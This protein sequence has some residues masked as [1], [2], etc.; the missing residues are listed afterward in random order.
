M[1]PTRHILTA[2]IHYSVD[3]IF[4]ED[5]M[6]LPWHVPIAEWHLHGVR[7][8]EIKRGVSRHVVIFVKTPRFSYCI[9]EIGLEVSKKEVSNYEMLLLNGIHTL[10]PVGTVS[11]EEAVIES[12]APIGTQYERTVT[13][14]TVTLLVEKVLPDSEL[15]QR[16]FSFVSR[17]AIWDAIAELFVELHTN[18]IL[19]G[20]ASLANTL[21]KFEKIDVPFVGKKTFLKAYLADAETVEVFPTLSAAQRESEI[22]YFFDSMD[23]LNEDLRISGLQRD[24]LTTENDKQYFRSR[25]DLLFT[26]EEKKKLFFRQTTFNIDAVLGLVSNPAYVDMFLEHIEEHKWYLCERTG[27]QVTLAEATQNWFTAIYAPL[28]KLF[29]TEG[30]LECFPGKTAA[31]LYIEIMTHKYFLSTQAGTDVGMV[32]AMNDYADTFGAVANTQSFMKKITDTMKSL[33]GFTPARRGQ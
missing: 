26:A 23:S 13:A 14:H 3:P 20:D 12:G 31:E 7:I 15:F 16:N 11:R 6:G 32:Q 10:V 4:V 2:P 19:W 18:G 8:L 5:L 1:Q 17:K 25:Y 21:V 22:R 24:A 30:V 28:C 33:I 9:K 29:R 27:T